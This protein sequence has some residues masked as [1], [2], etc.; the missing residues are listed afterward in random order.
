[1]SVKLQFAAL[2]QALADDL[3]AFSPYKMASIAGYG[4]VGGY[5]PAYSELRRDVFEFLDVCRN[6]LADGVDFGRAFE[7]PPL[8]RKRMMVERFFLEER[9][10][11][12]GALSNV[13]SAARAASDVRLMARF[14]AVDPMLKDQFA[15]L[16][17]RA[18]VKLEPTNARRDATL[19]ARSR[20][21]DASGRRPVYV[22]NRA[23]RVVEERVSERL[24]DARPAPAAER[25]RRRSL[26][27]VPLAND[28]L[29]RAA[30][31]VAGAPRDDAESAAESARAEAPDTRRASKRDNPAAPIEPAGAAAPLGGLLELSAAERQRASQMLMLSAPSAADRASAS[32][33]GGPVG[34]VKR[35]AM[36][37]G[38]VRRLEKAASETLRQRR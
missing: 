37:A 28:L 34:G 2:G 3:R 27:D 12:V 18:G 31:G 15:Y 6:V 32:L 26:F 17:R 33:D 25:G 30:L 13:A 10:A 24:V 7:L 22:S 5:A 29:A 1:M 20:P 11:L 36:D 14:A 19:G 4:R 35:G 9:D 38:D 8:V 16:L 23:Q 21:S